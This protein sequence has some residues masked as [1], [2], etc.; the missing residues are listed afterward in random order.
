MEH[1]A[2]SLH[3]GWRV[4]LRHPLILAPGKK[5]RQK[6]RRKRKK[7]IF[8]DESRYRRG[9]PGNGAIMCHLLFIL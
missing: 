2:E 8:F 1:T 7:W 4:P 9:S 5:G 3:R 6:K